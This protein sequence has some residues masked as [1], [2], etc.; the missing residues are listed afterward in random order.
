MN[1]YK[2][3]ALEIITEW[4]AKSGEEQYN[5]VRNCVLRAIRE[6]RRLAHGDELG[7]AVN[8][9][10]VM[11]ACNLLDADKL[12]RNIERR[13]NKGYGD[14]LAAIISRA[15]KANL[16]REIERENR[17]SIIVSE[18]AINAS[19]EEYSLFDSIAG[20]ADTERSAT[21]K[22]TL[23]DFYDGLDE[24]NKTIFCGMVKRLTEREIAPT[25]GISHVATH[26]RIAKI[27]AELKA[28]L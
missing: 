28:L 11:V 26:H 16:Q 9:T 14:S 23:K 19:G 8:S 18:T 13:A 24:R 4:N 17:D 21:I 10:Y 7:D 12:A 25:V 27:R 2:T 5:F 20:A 6:G 3:K 22:A 15:A 1:E